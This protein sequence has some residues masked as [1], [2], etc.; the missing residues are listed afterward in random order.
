MNTKLDELKVSDGVRKLNP[1]LFGGSGLT[2]AEPLSAEHKG[3]M[4]KALPG[5]CGNYAYLAPAAGQSR[6]FT[7]LGNP[8]GKP[9]MTQRDKWAKRPA[10]MR[11]RAWSDKARAS[12]KEQNFDLTVCPEAVSWVAYFDIPKS[13]PKKKR[14]AM[15]GKAHRQKP[16]RDNVDKAVLDTFWKEDSG[17]SRGSLEKR[18]D[19]GKGARIEV[20]VLL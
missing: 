15:E 19:D 14:L 5:V 2:G 16:D 17:V 10:V 12:A 9:R 3:L 8:M 7:V 4:A 18:W 1:G 20:E 13:W 6:I 11:Y